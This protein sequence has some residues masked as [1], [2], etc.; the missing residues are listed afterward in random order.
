M[1]QTRRI[2]VVRIAFVSHLGMTSGVLKI[3]CVLLP[4]L[5]FL[6]AIYF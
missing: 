5:H 4:S 3:Y 1:L 2:Q 6:M